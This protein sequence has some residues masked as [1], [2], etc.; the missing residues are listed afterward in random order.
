V[1]HVVPGALPALALLAAGIVWGTVDSRVR[2][3][4]ATLVGLGVALLTLVGLVSAVHGID[5]LE[6]LSGSV[7]LLVGTPVLVYLVAFACL[8]RRG[9]VRIGIATAAGVAGLLPLYHLG[10]YTLM[11]T[12]CAF[13][14][15]GC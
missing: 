6:A 2:V 8:V 14:P 4:P 3:V 12:A 11:R 9:G 5:G 15:G 7:P 13:G 1:S 10:G